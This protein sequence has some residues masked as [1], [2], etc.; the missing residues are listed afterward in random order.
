M[1]RDACRSA[2]S[3]ARGR[4][5]ETRRRAQPALIEAADLAIEMRPVKHPLKLVVKAQKGIEF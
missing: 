2:P 5:V 1:S 4:A 3:R